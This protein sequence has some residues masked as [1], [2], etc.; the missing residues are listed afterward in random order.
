MPT[1]CLPVMPEGHLRGLRE[2]RGASAHAACQHLSG[3]CVCGE[4]QACT[5]R[6]ADDS[7]GADAGPTR[8]VGATHTGSSTPGRFTWPIDGWLVGPA[9]LLDEK[10]GMK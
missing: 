9:R 2:T 1:C 3:A 5:R 8:R 7:N 4:A 6:G 10:P